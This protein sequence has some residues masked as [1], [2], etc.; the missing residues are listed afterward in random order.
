MK[1]LYSENPIF[2]KSFEE[3]NQ[4]KLYYNIFQ[5]YQY[6]R[7]WEAKLAFLREENIEIITII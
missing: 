7:L 6:I 2:L 1:K 4:V 3:F 5:K